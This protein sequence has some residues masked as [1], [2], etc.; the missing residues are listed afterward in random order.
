MGRDGVAPERLAADLRDVALEPIA[1][2]ACAVTLSRQARV[3]AA[4][5][6]LRAPAPYAARWTWDVVH[7]WEEPYVAGRRSRRR[8][9]RRPRLPR[10]SRTS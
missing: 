9:A 2:E 8:P 4:S 10:P 5:Q 7:I 6:A 1:D 3:G